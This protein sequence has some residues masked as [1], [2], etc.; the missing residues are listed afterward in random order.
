MVHEN[1]ERVPLD[2]FMLA[3]DW[4]L[5]VAPDCQSLEATPPFHMGHTHTCALRAWALVLSFSV[6]PLQILGP[7]FCSVYLDLG[8]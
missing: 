1:F 3:S 6:Q 4:T 7:T 8:R 2:E 5:R